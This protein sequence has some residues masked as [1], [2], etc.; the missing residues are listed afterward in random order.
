MAQSSKVINGTEYSNLAKK[1]GSLLDLLKS[2]TSYMYDALTIV[3]NFTEVE[4][5]RD[6]IVPFDNVYQQQVVALSSSTQFQEIAR[7]LNNHVLTRARTAGGATYS[8]INNWF[9]DQE[10]DGFDVG[11]SQSWADMSKLVGQNIDI[12]VEDND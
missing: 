8:D 10:L 4:P 1:Y 6:L 12:Y 7:A 9:A 3:A 2:A 5:T 11:F